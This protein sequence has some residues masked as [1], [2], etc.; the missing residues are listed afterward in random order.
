[1]LCRREM[2]LMAG[3]TRVEVAELARERSDSSYRSRA[4]AVSDSGFCFHLDDMDDSLVLMRVMPRNGAFSAFRFFGEFGTRARWSE[5]SYSWYSIE[6]DVLPSSWSAA[7]KS[8][9]WPG[10]LVVSLK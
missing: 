8:L 6:A 10:G 3:L 5:R 1:M 7:W 4:A 2:E 9:K